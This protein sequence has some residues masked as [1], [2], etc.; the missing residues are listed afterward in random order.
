MIESGKLVRE[1]PDI[2]ADILNVIPFAFEI[3]PATACPVAMR[4]N[5]GEGIHRMTAK[6][7]VSG[8]TRHHQIHE[9]AHGFYASRVHQSALSGGASPGLGECVADCGPKRSQYAVHCGGISRT[10]RSRLEG[11]QR[12][13]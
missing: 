1:K 10:R 8:R 11:R 4:S 2:A 7:S 13:Q 6:V 3:W 9:K 12:S 5:P